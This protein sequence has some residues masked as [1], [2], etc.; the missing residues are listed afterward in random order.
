MKCSPC[1]VLDHPID[2]SGSVHTTRLTEARA[3]T[4]KT[5][6][7]K[8]RVKSKKKKKKI[9]KSQP[10][11][12][13]SD[14]ISAITDAVNGKLSAPFYHILRYSHPDPHGACHPVMISSSFTW[15]KQQVHISRYWLSYLFH[16]SKPVYHPQRPPC[17]TQNTLSDENVIMFTVESMMKIGQLKLKC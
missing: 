10:M 8:K 11:P 4:L 7:W 15:K 3:K 5:R 16:Y 17:H 14:R 1:S 12:S 6:Y 13:S 9:Q 2:L